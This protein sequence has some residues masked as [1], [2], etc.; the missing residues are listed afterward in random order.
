VAFGTGHTSGFTD[1]GFGGGGFSGGGFSG[2]GFSGGGFSGGGFSGGGFSGGGFSGGGSGGGSG[3][4]RAAVPHDRIPN[5]G[6]AALGSRGKG[7]GLY[8]T[9]GMLTLTGTSNSAINGQAPTST[10]DSDG[11]A[12]Q[13]PF[14]TLAQLQALE[15]T[16]PPLT[17][18]GDGQLTQQEL[19]TTVSAA[20]TLLKQAG[21]SQQL[22]VRLESA[23]YEIG[24]LPGPLLGYTFTRDQTVVIDATAEGYGWYVDPASQTDSTFTRGARGIFAANPE[25]AAAGHMDLLT[26]VLHE[27][28]HLV[29]LGD[30]SPQAH[31]NNL[32]DTTLPT[33][34]RRTDALDAI[35]TRGFA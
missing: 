5:G 31:P 8:L 21:I 3:S 1:G 6:M 13:R 34:V 9:G 30:V 10:L 28:G 14:N 12:W 4:L 11:S 23:T 2:G 22:L 33:G 20:L 7:A 18:L 32:M 26:T 15:A 35:F 19:Q 27:M 24:N 29:G 16:L 25:S 17:S